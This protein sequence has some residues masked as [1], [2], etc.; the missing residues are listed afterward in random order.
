[1]K[2]AL[3]LIAAL[4]LAGCS[5]SRSIF[6]GGSSLIA[7]VQNPVGPQQLVAVESAVGAAAGTFNGYR[8]LCADRVLPPSCRTAVQAVQGHIPKVRAALNSARNFV[9]NYPTVSAA[10]AIGAVHAALG[11]FNAAMAANG[12]K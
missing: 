3:A 10:T 4:A 11:D 7:T 5:D 12:V 8:S 9:K 6:A 2:L 1:M